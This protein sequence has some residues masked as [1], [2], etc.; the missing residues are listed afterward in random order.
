[1]AQRRG[2]KRGVWRKNWAFGAEVKFDRWIWKAVIGD[3]S[4]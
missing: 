2:V 4:R 1:M 3:P